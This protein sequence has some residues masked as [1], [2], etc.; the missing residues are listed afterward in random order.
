MLA[1]R[2]APVSPSN[3]LT[4]LTVGADPAHRSA[5]GRPTSDPSAPNSVQAKYLACEAKALG[6]NSAAV[7][8]ETK[9]V[10]KGLADEFV[11]AFT[12]AGGSVSVRKVVPDGATD[13]SEFLTAAK[14]AAPSLLFFGGEYNVAAT[15]RTA[16]TGV[17][18]SAPLMGGDGMND[19]AV[20]RGRGCGRERLVRER[21][22]RAGR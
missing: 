6:F 9:A 4:S 8:S 15:L 14:P 7:V 22:R 21:R 19:P 12:A 17:G 3:T 13:F 18:I 16:A 5:S 2:G 20:H 11:A 1:K 10:S